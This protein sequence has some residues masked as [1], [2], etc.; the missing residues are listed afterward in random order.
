MNCRKIID[1]I[2]PFF[3]LVASNR[4]LLKK[5][6]EINNTD[7]PVLS[8]MSDYALLS[9]NQV[10]K[11]YEKSFDSKKII[12]DKIKTSLMSL[13]LASSFT[14]AFATIDLSEG[15]KKQ[16]PVVLFLVG[17]LLMLAIFYF[18]A[19]GVIALR[20]MSEINIKYILSPTDEGRA[21]QENEKKHLLAV[22]TELNENVNTIRCNINDHDSY[23]IVL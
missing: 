15:F 2:F 21:V 17:L 12:E 4:Y 20:A 13:T 6:E 18:I 19:S 16:G 3:R 1:E 8:Y 7:P 14:F 11:H 9:I 10:E 23:C 22:L 5:N